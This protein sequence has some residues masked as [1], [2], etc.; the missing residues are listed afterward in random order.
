[1]VATVEVVGVGVG[2]VDD[3]A[4]VV[5]VGVGVGVAAVEAVAVNSCLQC[6]HSSSQCRLSPLLLYACL[7]S[8][9]IL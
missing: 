8:S 5:G 1:V 3:V 9:H 6:C 2:V 4:G 7:V